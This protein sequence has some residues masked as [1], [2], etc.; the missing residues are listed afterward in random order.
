MGFFSKTLHVAIDA[1][2]VSTSLAGIKSSTGWAFKYHTL[3]E[4]KNIQKYIQNYLYCGEYTLDQA[5]K[6]MQKYPDF[7]EKS[8]K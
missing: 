1:L 3:T 4:D 8:S 7:F 6:L 5:A 2:L